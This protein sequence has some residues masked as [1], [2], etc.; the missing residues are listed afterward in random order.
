M[1]IWV[2]AAMTEELSFLSAAT[3]ARLNGRVAGNPW[4]TGTVGDVTVNLGVTGVGLASACMTLGAFCGIRQPD[5][6]VM[7]GSA[8]SLPESALKTG[9]MV[10]AET[11]IL[12]ELGVVA[13]PGIGDTRNMNLPGVV[14]EIQLD[15]KISSHLLDHA[16][17]LGRAF[18][19]RSLT[20]VGVS[21]HV[22]QAGDRAEH[23]RALA[24][25]MEGYALALAGQRF[26]CRT[27][28]LRGISNAAGDRDKC[29]WDFKNA[30][31]PPQKVVL[32]YLRERY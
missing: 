22:D 4:Y 1:N 9:D 15:S 23:F 32:E 20:V 21:A 17:N 31:I 29:R 5:L 6:M 14:Q 8:G 25:N 12:G 28:E 19:G 18:S 16:V 30:I 24:E 11:E 27:A 26:K 3:D 10:V 7:V 13:G 2:V